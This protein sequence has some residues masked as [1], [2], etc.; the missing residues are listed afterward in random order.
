V[1]DVGIGSLN[2]L[3]FVPDI[4]FPPRE[5]P[6]EKKKKERKT[7]D[8]SLTRHFHYLPSPINHSPCHINFAIHKYSSA[9]P[10]SLPSVYERERTKQRSLPLQKLA[11]ASAAPAPALPARS[12]PAVLP[13][14]R[15]PAA[16]SYFGHRDA[17]QT[18]QKK[19]SITSNTHLMKRLYADGTRCLFSG[20]A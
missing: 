8:R 18:A 14:P 6:R 15:Q 1:R 12:R 2:A 7:S 9:L 10:L 16:H 5:R 17:M 4:A 19:R 13:W 3:D 20:A 11:L